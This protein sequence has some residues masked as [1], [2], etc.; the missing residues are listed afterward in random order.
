[1]E[2]F[3]GLAIYPHFLVS[4]QKKSANGWIMLNLLY[5]KGLT[6]FAKYH[7]TGFWQSQ[8]T[9]EASNFLVK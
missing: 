4:S 9:I 5:S 3:I 6:Q 2:K 1:M 8:K 7:K